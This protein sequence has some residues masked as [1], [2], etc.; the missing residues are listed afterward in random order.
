[1]VVILGCLLA[2]CVEFN[3]WVSMVFAI[4]GLKV[5]LFG[6]LRKT[7]KN[8]SIQYILGHAGF[9]SSTVRPESHPRL[10]ACW[11]GGVLRFRTVG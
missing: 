10:W 3:F 8:H 7:V 6:Q 9:L 5:E 1:M 4:L 2:G 11:I